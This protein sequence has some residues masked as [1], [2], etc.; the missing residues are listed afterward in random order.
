MWFEGKR[1]LWHIKFCN[2]DP[3]GEPDLIRIL[4][5]MGPHGG[6]GD[7]PMKE[8]V[9]NAALVITAVIFS[10]IALEVGLR[11]YHG[12]WT[13]TNFRFPQAD[14]FGYHDYDAE[15]GWVPKQ[16]QLE[17]WGGTV[18]TGKEGIRVNGHGEVWDG[19]GDP[20]LAVG[21]SFTF[22][23]QVTDSE[24]WPAH[25]EK[26]SGNTVVNAG[27]DGYGVDQIFLRARRLLSRYRFSTVIFSFIPDDI[28]RSQMSVMFATAKPYFDF[29]EGRLTLEN[30]PVPSPSPPEQESEVLIGL[31]HSRL[32]HAVMK[33]LYPEWWLRA[34]PAVQVQDQETGIRVA[35]AL[36]N[37][38][39]GLTESQG[40]KFIVLAQHQKSQTP[41]E[42]MAAESVL[43]CLSNPA[44]RVVDL[45]PSS[46]E[47][48]DR[49]PARYR[50]LY[51]P[52]PG[53][54]MSSEGNR[55]VAT[56]I[57]PFVTGSEHSRTGTS[58]TR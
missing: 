33:R 6:E 13:F 12:E 10:L 9:K 26:L 19:T 15:L 56:E 31:E 20:L 27:V 17:A 18:T 42:T 47:M 55:F 14:K 7:G 57:L 41:S 16:Q 3:K 1:F 40:I 44:V 54:H 29:K 46:S 49:D 25:L 34:Q 24:T 4:A 22:G 43:S 39:G 21:D 32:A 48:Q 36:L 28:R 35:C 52:D 51:N 23:D 11:T 5:R 37:E 50:R 38:L 53:V 58:V 45:I 30:V 8:P 2:P